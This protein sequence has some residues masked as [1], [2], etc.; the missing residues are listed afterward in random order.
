MRETDPTHLKEKMGGG[1]ILL[2]PG[3]GGFKDESGPFR[4]QFY[5]EN[6]T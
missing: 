6:A 2:S 3:L 4:R 5:L 1:G